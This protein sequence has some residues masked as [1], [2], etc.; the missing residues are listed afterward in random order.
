MV[1]NLGNLKLLILTQYFPPEVGAPQARLSEMAFYLKEFGFQVEVLTA[2]PN[3]PKGKIFEGYKGKKILRENFDGIGIVRTRIFPTKS[4]NIFKRL[5]CYFSFVFY[6]YFAGKNYCQ[7]PDIIYM[8]SPPL[9][10][11]YSLLK[12]SKYW[13]VPY[14]LN[15]SDLW[16]DAFITLGKLKKN[17]IQYKLM[18]NLEKKLYKNALGITCQTRGILNEVKKLFPQ[19]EMELITNGVE[20]K[21][22]GKHL[23]NE[24]L[25]K[26]LGWDGKF[27]L[28]YTGLHGVSQGL[29]QIVKVA[30]NL[31][32]KED[33]FFS[34][35]GDGPEK[36]KLISIA[37]S[38][39]LKNI[40]FLPLQK[41][42][43][44][45]EILA[46]AEVAIIPLA[47]NFKEAVP[48]KTYEAMASGLPLISIS[49]GEVS[50]LIK[51][52]NMGLTVPPQDISS[53]KESIIS[54]YENNDKRLAFGKNA[55]K[56]AE[57]FYDRKKISEKLYNFL[58]KIY[59]RN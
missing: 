27:V 20:L 8:E 5:I 40:Q 38:Q 34:L 12:L 39:N 29:D 31:K 47:V 36:E 7:K 59:G 13:N 46:S 1:A 44:I 35:I 50:K 24:N 23:R 57:A 55:R 30:F 11:G 48:S 56:T 51:D 15:L 49:E 6:S 4:A 2:L 25:R 28:V 33:I 43:R 19:K 14:I 21:K 16:P 53:L 41:R 52:H 17:S 54:L 18:K 3:Y 45:P 37:K 58:I 32:E 9:F 42:E 10:L 22:F 26:E